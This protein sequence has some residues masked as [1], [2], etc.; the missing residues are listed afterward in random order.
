M[1]CFLAVWPSTDQLKILIVWNVLA[2]CFGSKISRNYFRAV[3]DYMT[4]P[5]LYWQLITKSAYLS[6]FW[7][8]QTKL[9]WY[10]D[11]SLLPYCIV[12]PDELNFLTQDLLIRCLST[13]LAF[14]VHCFELSE[15]IFGELELIFTTLCKLNFARIRLG[16]GFVCWASYLQFWNTELC[17]STRFAKNCRLCNCISQSELASAGYIPNVDF[18]NCVS[19]VGPCQCGLRP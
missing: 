3:T 15:L 13:G 11:S 10:V 16:A 1:T 9:S 18:W 7:L 12:K 17:F 2:I 19:S 8:H 6:D 4:S 14:L 5:K